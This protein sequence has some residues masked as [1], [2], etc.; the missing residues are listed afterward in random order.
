MANA[1]A[2]KAGVGIDP[3]RRAYHMF[4]KSGLTDNQINHIHGFEYD[5]EAEGP[6]AA[7]DPRKIQ[8]AVL[9]FYDK[10]WDVDRHRDSRASM[11]RSL[12]PLMG[13]AA[14]THRHQTSY[15]PRSRA[16]TKGSYAQEPR[17]EE[18]FPTEDGYEYND[19]D[20]FTWQ[21]YPAEEYDGWEEDSDLETFMAGESDWIH[22]DV[23]DPDVLDSYA[24]EECTSDKNLYEAYLVYKE[25]RD[26]LNQVRRGR[27]FWPVIAIPAPDGRSA[28]LA[29]RNTDES[30]RGKVR[31]SKNTTHKGKSKGSKSGKSGKSKGGK[32]RVVARVP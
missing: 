11:G 28:T 2:V 21:Q 15:H 1:D 20:E 8:E 12:R 3:D 14:A 17:E 22:R 25:A 24:E 13:H 16:G 30:F 10:P 19:W 7:L 9:R 18:T 32:A 29:V 31:D 4:I 5:A 23:L 26:T 6:G 27:G